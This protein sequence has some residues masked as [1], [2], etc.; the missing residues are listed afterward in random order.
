MR[1]WPQEEESESSDQNLLLLTSFPA[2]CFGLN[3]T[4]FL[5]ADRGQ[6]GH[7][8]HLAAPRPHML[9][10]VTLCVSPDLRHDGL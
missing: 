9:Q 8:E 7:S 6:C 5:T 3:A 4:G 2:Q 1:S 10:A